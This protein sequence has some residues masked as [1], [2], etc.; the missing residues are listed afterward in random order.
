M[1]CLAPLFCYMHICCSL[2][3]LSVSTFFLLSSSIPQVHTAGWVHILWSQQQHTSVLHKVLPSQ[4]TALLGNT[5]WAWETSLANSPDLW[6]LH[7]APELV[8]TLALHAIIA[9]ASRSNILFHSVPWQDKVPHRVSATA[10][11]NI[12][13]DA[14]MVLGWGGGWWGGVASLSYV[15]LIPC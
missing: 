2:V 15:S 10:L 12:L 1:L 9:K 14:F 8:W 4:D 13:T 7:A 5:F 6:D 3:T 11:W